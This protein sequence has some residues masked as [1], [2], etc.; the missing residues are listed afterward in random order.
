MTDV[1]RCL[2]V[3]AEKYDP[4]ADDEDDGT[5]QVNNVTYLSNIVNVSGNCHRRLQIIT[6]FT[7]R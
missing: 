1:M 3:A 7:L 4:E 6:H 2:A 5:G